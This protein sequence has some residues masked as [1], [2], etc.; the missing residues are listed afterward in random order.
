MKKKELK[1]KY[2]NEYDKERL[3]FLNII[4]KS[5]TENFMECEKNYLEAPK[6]EPS[7]RMWFFFKKECTTKISELDYQIKQIEKKFVFNFDSASDYKKSNLSNL[8]IALEKIPF[9][10]E[11]VLNKL[12]PN[13]DFKDAREAVENIS[14]KLGGYHGDYKEC[15]SFK[16]AVD[17]YGD[18]M[19]NMYKYKPCY[20]D[21][22][23]KE[24]FGNNLRFD[25]DKGRYTLE[26]K[27]K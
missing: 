7:R 3:K 4:H 20:V 15:R 27:E 16:Q 1:I 24:T 6:G 23:M 18:L 11:S 10:D 14:I 26:K 22:F 13:M 17:V 19:G 25:D 2:P 5:T 21:K 9:F 8:E 12:M